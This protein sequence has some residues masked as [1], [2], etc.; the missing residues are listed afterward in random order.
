MT[1]PFATLGLSPSFDLDLAEAERRHRELSKTLH[2]DR[3]VGKPAT[4]RRQAL[5][6]AIEVNDAW[7]VLKDPIRR[8]EALLAKL[9]VH[10]EED[11]EPKP[12]PELLMDMLEKREALAE[13]GRAR[14]AARVAALAKEI[15]AREAAATEKLSARFRGVTPNQNA[16]S[17]AEAEAL[18]RA[19]GELRYYRRFLDEARALQ[20]EIL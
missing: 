18:L 9:G 3:Y 17:A 8:G 15:G 12:D 14:D 13:A 19:L 6:R 20:D 2:P 11:R 1:D 5:G 4:E 7:R 10:V 16:P